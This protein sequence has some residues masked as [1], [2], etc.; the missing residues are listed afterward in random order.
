[1][2]E[3]DE[4][5]RALETVSPAWAAAVSAPASDA[6]RAPQLGRSPGVRR[7]VEAIHEGWLLHRGASRIVAGASPDLALLVGDW[8]YAAGLCDVAEHG[9][10]DD[11]LEL[12]RLVTTVSAEHERPVEE[13]E[14]HWDDA[15]RAL[16][17]EP[18]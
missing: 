4:I 8:A 6:A 1:M 3:L 13:L 12:A 5:T 15:L 16:E 2:I 7:G 14:A 11:V 18:S 9:T 17:A 10:L